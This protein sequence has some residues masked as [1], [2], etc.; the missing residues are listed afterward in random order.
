MP[1]ISGGTIIEG[2]GL[3]TPLTGAGAPVNGTNEVQTLT[4]GGTPTGGTFK[5]AFDGYTTAAITWSATNGTLIANVDTALEALSSIGTGGVTC[6]DSTLSSG[7]GDLTI[8]FA[9]TNTAKRVQA[10]ITV[11]L[12]SLTGTAPTVEVAETTAGVRATGLG[13]SIGAL[14]LDVTNGALYQNT[15]T[16]D[17]PVWS[18]T[19]L[20]GV[21]S[22]A[23]EINTLD[24]VTAGTVTASK[25]VVVDANKDIGTFRHITLSGNIV[26]GA[27]TLSETDLAKIDGIT[28]GT[29]AASK[30]VVNDANANQGVAKVTALHIGTSGSET[31]VGATAAELNNAADVSARVQALTASGAVTAGVQSVELNHASVVIAATIANANAHQGLFVVKDTSA[32]G[33]AAHTLTLTAGTFNGTNNVATFDARDEMLVVYFDSA[34]RGQVIANVGTVGLS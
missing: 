31:Q 8:T 11:A 3:G 14:Y 33:T 7:I 1:V 2:G 19:D 29:Q 16:S 25:A 34:G 9:G 21:T 4:I 13:S 22:S 18:A 30:A 28:N 12:N 17:A 32:T 23:D 5:L 24:G 20:S 6:A 27:T 10:L 26:T 15:G